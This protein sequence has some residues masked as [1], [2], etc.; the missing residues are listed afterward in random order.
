MDFDE[1]NE[2]IQPSSDFEDF[3][4]FEFIR[5]RS[6]TDDVDEAGTDYKVNKVKEVKKDKKVR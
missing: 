5:P 2:F 6:D 4:L 3:G 1:L